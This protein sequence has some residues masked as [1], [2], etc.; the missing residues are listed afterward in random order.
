MFLGVSTVVA[1]PNI[2]MIGTLTTHS[3]V[4][5]MEEDESQF[6]LSVLYIKINKQIITIYKCQQEYT[7][8]IY[9]VT[10]WGLNG[11]RQNSETQQYHLIHVTN[12][13]Y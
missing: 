12:P 13:T 4:Q 3:L 5:K 1:T 11:F 10:Q 2:K 9:T 7:R 6:I 8:N